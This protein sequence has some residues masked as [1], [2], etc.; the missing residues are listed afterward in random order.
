MKAV[1]ESRLM[2]FYGQL[3]ATKRQPYGRIINAYR[4]GRVAEAVDA[5]RCWWD[6][7][8]QQFKVKGN[9]FWASDFGAA[10]C[11]LNILT[12]ISIN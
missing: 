12:G 4:A 2:D 9:D 1:I 3:P 10:G 11:L 5:A 6:E 7:V 8:R